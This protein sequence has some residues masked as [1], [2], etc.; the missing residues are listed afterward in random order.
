M[1]EVVCLYAVQSGR[2]GGGGGRGRRWLSPHIFGLVVAAARGDEAARATLR[3]YGRRGVL[4]MAA[5]GMGVLWY[6][7]RLKHVV[8]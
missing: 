3:E 7:I 6:C 5:L 2:G 8:K 4:M 1:A